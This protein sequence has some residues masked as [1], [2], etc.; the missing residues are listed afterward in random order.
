M[1]NLDKSVLVTW[2]NVGI[3]SN[4]PWPTLA[5][6]RDLRSGCIVYCLY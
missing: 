2:Q 1:Y 5:R 3:L 6:G 4:K